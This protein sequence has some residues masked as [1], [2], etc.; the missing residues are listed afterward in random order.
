[1]NLTGSYIGYVNHPPKEISEEDEDQNAHLDT[2]QPKMINF[3]GSSKSHHE[4]MIN[5][6]LNLDKGVTGGAFSLSLDDP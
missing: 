5:K 6:T 1:M 3:I 4:L 2:S